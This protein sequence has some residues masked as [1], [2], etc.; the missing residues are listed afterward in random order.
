MPYLTP[1]GSETLTPASRKINSY[2]V[3]AVSR[4]IF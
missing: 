3:T 1:G 4:G 2:G